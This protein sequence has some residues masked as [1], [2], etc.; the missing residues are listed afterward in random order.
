[1]TD[2][3]AQLYV[4]PARRVDFQRELN[5]KGVV[6]GFEAQMYRQD[7][8]VIWTTTNARAVRD[9]RGELL[10]EGIIE[11][12]TE[13]KHLEE[14]L[15]RMQRVEAIGALASGL[16]HDLNNIL[17]PMLMAAGMLKDKLTDQTDRDILGLAEQSVRRGAKIIAQLLTFGRGGEGE[18]IGV[19]PENLIEEI[20]RIMQET[21]PR[22]IEIVREIP[23]DLWGVVTDPT[24]MHQVL[25]N[26]CVN[27]R[28][29]MPEGGRLT[30]AARNVE[31]DEAGAGGFAEASPGRYVEL[32]VA[33]T[34]QGIPPELLSRIFDPFFT[35]KGIGKGT[36]LGLST[37]SSIVKNHGGF[38]TVE[39]RMGEGTVFAIRIPAS[40]VP[41]EVVEDA[42][43]NPVPVG[44][45][46][47]ILVVDDEANIQQLLRQ[48]LEN[49]HYHVLTAANGEEAL[50]TFVQHQARVRLVLTDVLM[51][52][53]GGLAL[54][55]ALRML[56][57]R[58]KII[59]CS[60]QDQR[61]RT[62][63]LAAF[64]VMEVLAKP[65]S[66]AYLLKM[67]HR[68]LTEKPAAE[69][70]GELAA[71]SVAELPGRGKL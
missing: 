48:N 2:I 54:I 35:T 16:A 24:Q 5:D 14:K 6:I 23:N 17:V 53:M 12:I 22:D 36:G 21:F 56:E 19:R 1:V 59:A 33:D 25:M 44:K 29:A 64:G 60:G 49:N 8:R 30:L 28:D 34:G 9:D 66:S 4:K 41:V 52:G 70:P 38:L 37:V 7:G 42:P 27:A 57:P 32:S 31:L 67:L 50:R 40:L 51:P 69:A 63:E 47:L 18:R 45:G 55:R 61:S 20:L 62:A 65:F 71:A 3:S 10:Y 46:E 26:L 43:E 58:L 15:L 39:S 11:D 68:A 13:R